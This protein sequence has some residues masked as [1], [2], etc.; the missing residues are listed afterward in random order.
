MAF[1]IWQ[2]IMVAAIPTALGIFL[3]F[4]LSRNRE[5][6]ELAQKAISST[7][8]YFAIIETLKTVAFLQGQRIDQW[9]DWGRETSQVW[10]QWRREL[11]IK[12]FDYIPPDLPRM[13][14]L[15]L[16][17]RPYW[18]QIDT[19]IQEIS[20]PKKRT[21]RTMLVENAVVVDDDEDE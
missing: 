20:G 7:K 19:A 14:E 21:K 17:L 18:E 10:R 4:M 16:D 13:P 12:A 1:D 6:S 15:H 9:E 8:S 2:T 5:A 3:T 11:R